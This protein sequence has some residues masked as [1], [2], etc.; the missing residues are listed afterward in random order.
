MRER[1][2]QWT[3]EELLARLQ[4]GHYEEAPEPTP[5]EDRTLDLV[6]ERRHQREQEQGQVD[7]R[8]NPI[9]FSAGP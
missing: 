1:R 5:E 4:A 9:Y 2:R 7:N 6:W 3:E 8:N